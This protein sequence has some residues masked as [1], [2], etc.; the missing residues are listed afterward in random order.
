MHQ[1]LQTQEVVEVVALLRRVQR[2][3]PG[4]VAPGDAVCIA[5]QD[6][7]I[8]IDASGSL[9][10]EGFKTM[11][12]FTAKLMDKY[13]GFYYGED[14]MAISVVQ[15]GNGEILDD[16]SISSAKPIIS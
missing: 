8:S 14:D 1:E 11:K 9:T 16:G 2:G 10:E 15:F 12:G 3:L 7:V 5:T 6:L 4:E 13:M